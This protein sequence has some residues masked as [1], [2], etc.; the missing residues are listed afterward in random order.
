MS[1]ARQLAQKPSQPTGRKNMLINGS[2]IVSQRGTQN[3]TSDA[4]TALDRFKYDIGGSIA[5]TFATTQDS[6]APDGF[7]SSLKFNCTTADTPASNEHSNFRHVIEAQNLQH[8]NYGTSGAKTTTLSFWVKASQAA[9]YSVALYQSDDARVIG[10]TYTISATNTWEYKTITFAGD[11]SGTINNDNGSG[12]EFI[13]ALNVGSNFTATDNTSWGAYSAG[14][15]AYGHTATIGQTSGDYL[16]ITGVQFEVGSVA[17]DFEHRSY[18]EEF[19]L[20][21]RYFQRYQWPHSGAIA[22]GANWNGSS[23]YAEFR[24]NKEMRA[25][26]T[27]ADDNEHSNFLFLQAGVSNSVTGLTLQ[28]LSAHS[29]EINI[30]GTSDAVGQAGWLRAANG[31]AAFYFDAEL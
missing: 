3:V 27:T 29:C 23:K 26:P 2:M 4:Y 21:Q 12:L 13:F 11:T 19:D 1:K 31:N 18:A 9:T 25:A 16:Y 24:F 10:S 8:L 15:F 28:N 5:A 17:T 7:G 22:T 14:K 30:A 6:D 20:C